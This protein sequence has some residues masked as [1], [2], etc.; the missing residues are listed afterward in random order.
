MQDNQDNSPQSSEEQLEGPSQEK[1]PSQTTESEEMPQWMRKEVGLPQE[2]EK[3][4]MTPDDSIAKEAT[5]L[6]EELAS[7]QQQLSAMRARLSSMQE[8]QYTVPRERGGCLT[9]WLIFLGIAA[10]LALVFGL[11]SAGNAG[12]V[13]LIYLGGG[14]VILVGVVGVWQLKKWGYYTLMTWY[15]LGLIVNILTLCVQSSSGGGALPYA[16]GAVIGSIISLSI[17]YLLA[18][19]RWEAF[20]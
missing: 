15:T 4:S 11:L 6:R 20:D 7:N 12:P 19:D 10:A 3:V 8:Q 17:T 9:A 16:I 2:A 1:Q 13:S 18:H 5:R 14:V